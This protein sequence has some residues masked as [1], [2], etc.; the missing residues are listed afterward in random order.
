MIRLF[1]LFGAAPLPQFH[2]SVQ[3]TESLAG[4][5]YVWLLLRAF[6]GGCTALTGI[7]AISNG[8][9]AFIRLISE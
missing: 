8:V 9:Q 3:A 1:G 5:A 6:A 4:F 2:E 7:E